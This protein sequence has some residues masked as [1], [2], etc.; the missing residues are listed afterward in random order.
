MKFS[1]NLLY[2]LAKKWPS[3]MKKVTNILGNDF[4]SE[5]YHLNYSL[6]RQYLLK[7]KYGAPYDFWDKSILKEASGDLLLSLCKLLEVSWQV[8]IDDKISGW[9]AQQCISALDRPA[10]TSLVS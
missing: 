1:E 8:M 9:Q 4:E 2:H 6:H 5:D 3:P 7:A 10:Y